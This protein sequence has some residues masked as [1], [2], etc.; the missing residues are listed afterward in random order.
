MSSSNFDDNAFSPTFAEFEDLANRLNFEDDPGDLNFMEIPF[1]P[2]DPNPGFAASISSGRSE[3]ESADTV[4][5]F[6]NT[7]L[8]EENMEHRPSMFHDPLA[9]QSTEKSLYDVIGEKYPISPSQPS[10]CFN[11]N[12]ESPDQCFFGG[13]REHSINSISSGALSVDSQRIVNLKEYKSSVQGY[14]FGTSFGSMENFSHNVRGPMSSSMSSHLVPNIFSVSQPIWQFHGGVESVWQFNRGVEEASKFLPNNNGLVM[15]LECYALPPESKGGAPEV[16]GMVGDTKETSPSGS[17][18]RKNHHL[19]DSNRVV[20]ERNSKFSAIHVEES[21]LSE[22]FDKVLLLDLKEEA[23]CCNSEEEVLSEATKATQLNGQRH[24]S[25]CGK[26]RSKKQGKKPEAVDLRTLLTSCAHSLAASDHRT[27]NEQLKQIRQHSSP[28]GD[29]SRRLANFFANGLEARLAGTGSQIYAALASKRISAAE[30]LKAYQLILS[31]CP[32]KKMTIFFANRTILDLAMNSSKKKLHIIDF[33]I[34]YGFQWP[35]VIQHLSMIPGGPPELRIT[36][37][38]LPQHGFRPP[39][40]VEETGRRLAKYCECFNVKFHYHAIAQ[41]WETINIEDLNIHDD[42]VLAVNCICRFENLLD[43]T[44]MD[45]SPRDTVLKLIRKMKPNI[46]IQSHSNASFSSPFFVPRFREAL[47]HYSSLFDM[48]DANLPRENQERMNYEQEFFGR[49]IMSLIA[50][51]GMGRSPVVAA[52]FSQMCIL[53]SVK[54]FE[55]DDGAFSP[56]FSPSEDLADA[57]RF[58]DD[59]GDLSMMDKF[60]PPVPNPDFAAL[61]SS[62]SSELD[63][64]D[65]SD[66]S[67]AV[68]KFINTTL[69]EENMEQTTS[70]FHDPLAL[71]ATEKSLYDV[72]GEK[73]PVSPNQPPLYFNQNSESPDEYLFST[74]SEQSINS[75]TNRGNS[76]DTQRTVDPGAFRYCLKTTTGSSTEKSTGSMKEALDAAA[77]SG[78]DERENS[79]NGSRG[80]KNHHHEDNELEEVR[81]TKFSTIY[82]EE[83]ELSDMFDKV[84]L[85]DV[86]AKPSCCDAH[87]EVQSEETKTIQQN[88][89]PHGSKGRKTRA[90]KKKSKNEVVDLVTLLINCA[91]SVAAEDRWSAYEQLKNIR[92]HSSPSGDGFQR[93]ANVFANGLEARLAGT[94][95]QLYAALASKRISAAEKL[96]A[97][98]L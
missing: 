62:G 3:L 81:S 96:K 94:G 6:I 47:F 30:T 41:K 20:E 48:L 64:P 46:F 17:R 85:C 90:K 7:I 49:E 24:G 52:A 65:D 83:S 91:Q 69:M 29:G 44:V 12:V 57:F 18:G 34:L 10:L 15:D 80:R 43:D 22:M 82:V 72:I 50:C 45:D 9:L 33:G 95:S 60:L 13:S 88:G 4:L 11:Q 89:H 61:N 5:K 84:L 92:Q 38:E 37:I 67:D 32:F 66:F 19:K 28:I 73:Y 75:N 78:K 71:R 98:Q 2:H 59:P 36:G 25:K 31:S 70:T 40:F 54:G 26:T 14:T 27:A 77:E 79:P 93:L 16:V 58:R 97:Y 53:L 74:S 39:E 42:E 23:A 56:T 63:S 51:E 86:K 68:L 76:V 1:L 35:M 87:E 21:E 55:F 8:M